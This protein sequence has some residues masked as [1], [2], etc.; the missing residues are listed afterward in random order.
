MLSAHEE[1]VAGV[2]MTLAKKIRRIE[3][4]GIGKVVKIWKKFY[5]ILIGSVTSVS[6]AEI[7]PR[8]VYTQ[9]NV[10]EYYAGLQ[11]SKGL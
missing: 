4:P 9:A 11:A 6:A 7:H 2:A 10:G 8:K 1:K 3:K 5:G